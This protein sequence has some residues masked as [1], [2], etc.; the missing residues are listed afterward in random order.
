MKGLLTPKEHWE[1]EGTALEKAEEELKYFLK[2]VE[3]LTT[4]F[5]RGK[6]STSLVKKYDGLIMQVIKDNL[7]EFQ[8]TKERL[9]EIQ[10]K[11]CGGEHF[12]EE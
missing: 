1:A 6:I 11:R 7:R 3:F 5:K 8:S 2:D 4:V 9:E 12:G 10:G